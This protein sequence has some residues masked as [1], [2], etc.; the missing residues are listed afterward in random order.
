MTACS[1][2]SSANTQTNSA[3]SDSKNQAPVSKTVDG[4]VD[5]QTYPISKNK[6]TLSLWY[7]MAGSIGE[8][9]NFNDSEFFQWYEKKTNIHINFI[10][11]A[12][13]T[14]KDA[15]KLLLASDNM[16][17]MIY[18]Q[19]ND[20]SYPTGEDKALDDGVFVDM[21]KYLDKAPNYVSWL[22]NHPDFKRGAYSDSGKMYG[23]WGVWKTMGE[24]YLSDNGIAIRKDFLDKVGKKVPTT[25]DEWYDVLCA[26]RDKLHVKAPLYTTKYGIDTT[27][28]FMAGFDT[29]PYFYQRNGKACFG[30]MDDQYKAY[31]TMLNKWWKEGLLDKDFAT[32]KTQDVAPDKD[33]V[34]NDNIGS[35]IDWGTRL[36][37]AYVTRGATNKSF[38]FVGAPQPKKSGAN[39]VDPAYRVFSSGNDRMQGYCTLFNSNS[40]N[41]E[42]AI[43]WTDGFY[44]EDV[45]LNA[46]YG[47]ESEKNTTWKE[48]SD[49]HRIGIYDFRY[50]NPNGLDSA[51]VAVKYWAKNPPVRV[52]AAQFEQSDNIIQSGYKTWATYQPKNWISTRITLSSDEGTQ[53]ASAYT[54]ILT[55]VQENNA[56][57]IMGQIPL[58]N[59]DNYR[60]TLKKMGIE[61]CIS[62][63]QAALDR[64]NKRGK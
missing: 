14:E 6:I 59:Y 17:D 43:R 25:Y 56:K 41:L 57:F 54:D 18:C 52:E 7:P 36:S 16:P 49:G 51:T 2:G 8:L 15:F 30:P 31:L 39:A 48:A 45:Y 63:K 26:F 1:G 55:Y 32:R 5:G 47:L 53:F 3:A 33:M 4:K 22:D 50:K 46:S 23:M 34:L 60:A 35:C 27:G 42:Q 9:S 19:P 21:T 40:K 37:N 20:Q 29:A 13:G 11:P 62:I 61:N 12:V 28:E 44:A 38:V 24:N 58:S 64:Y 10:V